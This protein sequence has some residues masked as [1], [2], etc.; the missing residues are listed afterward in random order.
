MAC[1]CAALILGYV[2]TKVTFAL[3]FAQ[4]HVI[5]IFSLQLFMTCGT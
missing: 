4:T 1:A 3:I 2:Q 5:P